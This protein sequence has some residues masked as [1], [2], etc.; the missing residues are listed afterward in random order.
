MKL[1][2][3]IERQRSNAVA[4]WAVVAALAAVGLINLRRGDPLWAGLA[5]AVVAVA[6]VPTVVTRNPT[7]IASWE[8]LLLAAVPVGAHVLGVFAEPVA[9]VAVATLALLIA[10]ELVAFSSAEMTPW[11]AVAFVVMTTS[12]VA[13]LWGIVQFSADQ[14]L[15]TSLL[16]G[17]DDLMWDLVGATVVG[18]GAG[19][20]FELYFRR[21]SVPRDRA[22]LHG[23]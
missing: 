17:R 16:V 3:L 11:F 1:G 7:V 13:A 10:V 18:V 5:V 9:Y 15:G 4:S 12:S 22:A 2:G 21:R 23:E 6:L 19:L 20:L 8:A 14:F